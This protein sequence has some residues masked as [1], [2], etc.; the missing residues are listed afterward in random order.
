MR[1]WAADLSPGEETWVCAEGRR[2]VPSSRG[3]PIR[4]GSLQQANKSLLPRSR[5]PGRLGTEEGAT[6]EVTS[7]QQAALPCPLKSRRKGHWKHSGGKG[8]PLGV[9]L[10]TP[11][12][13]L[14]SAWVPMHREEG[15]SVTRNRSLPQAHPPGHILRLHLR[16]EAPGAPQPRK[17]PAPDRRVHDRGPAPPEPPPVPPEP[18]APP[19]P[20]GPIDPGHTLP[21]L[22]PQP[23]RKVLCSPHTSHLPEATDLPKIGVALL[24][25][26]LGGRGQQSV[27][28]AGDS[29]AESGLRLGSRSGPRGRP[30]PPPPPPRPRG[31]PS[32]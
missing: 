6:P 8:R 12:A 32:H 30:G 21:Q 24:L 28:H 2:D 23:R 10:L 17:P 19:P 9:V 20:P 16:G 26:L 31:R 29:G 18:S 1:D 4:L 5:P 22:L 11:P 27:S 7:H 13:P 14:P 15:A 25:Q 3:A